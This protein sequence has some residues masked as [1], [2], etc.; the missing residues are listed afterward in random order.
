[1]KHTSLGTLPSMDS[2]LN[3]QRVCVLRKSKDTSLMKHVLSEKGTEI[4][5]TSY[6]EETVPTDCDPVHWTVEFVISARSSNKQMRWRE[7]NQGWSITP[8]GHIRTME[9]TITLR[10]KKTW[11]GENQGWSITPFGRVRSGE[12]AITPRLKE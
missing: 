9:M 5:V 1:M 3:S 6:D 4:K 10:L 2:Q 8:F 12:L 7:E 11:D